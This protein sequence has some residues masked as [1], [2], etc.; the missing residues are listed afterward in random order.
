M[1]LSYPFPSLSLDNKP[2]SPPPSPYLL[3]LGG[4]IFACLSGFAQES[5]HSLYTLTSIFPKR[6]DWQKYPVQHI[7][8]VSHCLMHI[9]HI[10]CAVSNWI[11]C[12]CRYINIYTIIH[13]HIQVQNKIL[14]DAFWLV[15][16]LDLTF[17]ALS[18]IN[19][20]YRSEKQP[21]G[22]TSSST[23]RFEL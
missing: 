9:Q 7:Q 17:S 6:V 8:Y 15:E 13:K 20:L 5:D 18:Q 21:E 12:I 22:R 14:S 2:P 10:Q 1:T 3:C 11:C 23:W 16:W 19:Y 4:K